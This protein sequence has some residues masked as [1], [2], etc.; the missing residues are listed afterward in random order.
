MKI[1]LALFAV[2]V[3]A[4]APQP[5]GAVTSPALVGEPLHCEGAQPSD[6]SHA[7]DFRLTAVSASASTVL[8]VAAASA[9]PVPEPRPW[10]LLASGLAA[11]L[12]VARRRLH[13]SF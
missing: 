8:P 1:L 12:W 4:C 9:A 10:P 2:S 5:V 3:L 6:Y 7:D 11:A 13:T